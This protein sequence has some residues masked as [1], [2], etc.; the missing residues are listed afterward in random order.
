MNHCRR[1]ARIYPS[2]PTGRINR[3]LERIG[4]WFGETMLQCVGY[5]FLVSITAFTVWYAAWQV[6]R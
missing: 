1:S 3:M 5:A 6:I 2:A 4:N